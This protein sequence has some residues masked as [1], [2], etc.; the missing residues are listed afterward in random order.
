MSRVTCVLAAEGDNTD[1]VSLL[2]REIPHTQ[3]KDAAAKQA[4]RHLVSLQ[5]L[6]K[7][8]A[9]RRAKYKNQLPW[10]K[11][12]TFGDAP[13]AKGSLRH[14]ANVTAIDGI[15]GD[16][17]AGTLTLAEAAE[18]LRRAGVAGLIYTSPSHTPAQPRWRVLVPLSKSM[19]PDHRERL[20]ARL[21]G[22]L[23][24]ALAE[25]SF[26]LSQSYYYG[27]AD[28][29]EDKASSEWRDGYPVEISL[30]DGAGIDTLDRLDV[31][32]L[33]KWGKPYAPIDLDDFMY[34]P[35]HLLSESTDA[36]DPFM[37]ISFPPN[38]EKISSALTA[39]PE[40]A[41]ADRE[42]C[43]RPIGMALHHIFS[44]SEEGF[45]LWHDWSAVC[46][47]FEGRRPQRVDW[48]SFGNYSGK[49]VG[50]GTIF[51]TAMTFGWDPKTWAKQERQSRLKLLTPSDCANAPSRGYVIKG[52]IA[53][54]DVACIFGAPGGGKST[55][56]P[57]FGYQ[58]ARGESAFG[59]RTKQGAVF[60]VATED[61]HGMKN[62]VTALRRRGGD[63][64]DFYL[65]D[66]VTDLLEQDSPDLAELR[67]AV[68]TIQPALIFIDTLAMAFLDLEENDAQSMNRV[69]GIARSLT[70]YGAAVVLI[71][72][73]T[74]SGGSTPRGH[75][76][77]NG[78]LDVA[79]QL[80][81]A[82]DNGIIRG[83]LTKNRNGPPH[84]DIAFRVES[85][86]LG[87]D[88]DGDPITAAIVDELPAGTVPRRAKL[89]RSETAALSILNEM[90]SAG[91]VS[92]ADWRRACINSRSVSGA[93]KQDSR[94]KAFNRAL[95]EL[96][97]KRLIKLMED[98]TVQPCGPITDEL[99]GS[100][101]DKWGRT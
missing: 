21:Q 87:Q 17:D 5:D 31:G 86:E 97:R 98:G 63:A 10:L 55:I 9:K 47:N 60:Y 3:F 77:L 29:V 44:G 72:H 51:A 96:S 54:R 57:H 43:W 45:E 101:Y 33:D 61:S 85:T 14:N 84:L 26:T 38:V 66:G 91:N 34:V 50:E 75:S 68:Q 6:A 28:R 25:E 100:E 23:G 49:P 35:S 90:A 40:D 89:S 20:C 12:A 11:L 53:P 32:A 70:C 27:K 81:P 69:V 39:I 37:G 99:D 78:A 94:R 30:I 79:L 1:C 73:D 62:R 15:E 13:T 82:I 95:S 58:V 59:L 93:E 83:R 42:G 80:L 2:D 56:A 92:E 19:H 24:G 52:L 48:D 4:F 74:K 67:A 18:R 8:I 88:E 16:H 46:P 76:V 65:V 22:V 7:K 41:R 36:E 71:H 64:P